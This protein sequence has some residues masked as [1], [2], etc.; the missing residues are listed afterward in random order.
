MELN[1]NSSE[2]RLKADKINDMKR[3]F[4][5][6]IRVDETEL[7]QA[8]ILKDKFE[9]SIKLSSKLPNVSDENNRKF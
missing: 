2:D 7:D 3:S 5:S 9:K 6:I 1:K 4:S 8:K